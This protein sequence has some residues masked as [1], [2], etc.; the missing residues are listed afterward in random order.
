MPTDV[1]R[2]H[3][4]NLWR[5]PLQVISENDDLYASAILQPWDASWSARLPRRALRV[6]PDPNT[7]GLTGGV[8][9]DIRAMKRQA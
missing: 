6:R 4:H 2:F 9:A 7:V 5:Y 8:S 3:T 1:S